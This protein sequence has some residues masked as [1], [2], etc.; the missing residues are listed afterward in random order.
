MKLK[1]S[2][3]VL[4]STISVL[5]TIKRMALGFL[6]LFSGWLAYELLFRPLI[7]G[8]HFDQAAA[9]VVL[10]IIVAYIFIPMA[11]RILTK[12]YIPD[13]FI[14]RIRTIDGLLSDPVNL[15]FIGSEDELHTAMQS[16]GWSPAHKLT[17]RSGFWTIVCML[18]RESY[19]S[20]PVSP[21]YLFNNK[22]NFT[23][24]Q[25]I[26]NKPFARH[27]VRF[28]KVPDGWLMPGGYKVDWLAA[29][30]F[31]RTVGFSYFTLQITHRIESDTD[32]E[33]DY[34]VKTLSDAGKLKS[35][36]TI[37][38]YFSAYHHR[39]GGGDSITTDGALPIIEL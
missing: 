9:F 22:Q 16:A 10:W 19:V 13:Y 2:A 25:N 29:G 33:R 7:H 38:S 23:Y 28:F 39:N 27:H 11:H 24:Q 37:A 3:R 12:L 14:G 34:I 31:D 8:N 18:K 6:L 5:M 35:V 1:P 20:A 36:K 4:M 32:I 30:T 17:P 21:G 15:A 26:K